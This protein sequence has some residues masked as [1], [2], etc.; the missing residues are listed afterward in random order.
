MMHSYPNECPEVILKSNVKHPLVENGNSKL[1]VKRILP[2]G[3]FSM[4]CVLNAI[5]RAFFD[6]TITS[7][8]ME[9]YT[10]FGLNLK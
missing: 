6:S 5:K 2:K 4:S 1:D 7:L 8:T 3:A 10:A 9:E